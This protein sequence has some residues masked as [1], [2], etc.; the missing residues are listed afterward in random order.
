MYMLQCYEATMFCAAL[1]LALT[2]QPLPWPNV[3]RETIAC[4]AV[5]SGWF[6]CPLHRHRSTTPRPRHKDI[7]RDSLMPVE[8]TLFSKEGTSQ[9][10]WRSMRAISPI[11]LVQTNFTI[12]TPGC[13]SLSVGKNSHRGVPFFFLCICF[14]GQFPD[15]KGQFPIFSQ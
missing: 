8:T 10:P 7:I 6:S 9:K 15:V 1:A 4:P 5:G 11:Q 12:R 13:V 2:F 14:F 3:L